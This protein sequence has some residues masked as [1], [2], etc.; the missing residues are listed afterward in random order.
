MFLV[1]FDTTTADFETNPIEYCTLTVDAVTGTLQ[2]DI[3]DL[4]DETP[5][6]LCNET[7]VTVDE[8]DESHQGTFISHCTSTSTLNFAIQFS[9]SVDPVWAAAKFEIDQ[10]S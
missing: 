4:D 6:T 3:T 10:A 5:E 7:T 2:I 9:M 1:Q 8:N